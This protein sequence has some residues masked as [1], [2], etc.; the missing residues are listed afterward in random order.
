MEDQFTRDLTDLGFQLAGRD[1]RG[2]LQYARRPNRYLTQWVHDDGTY[3][4]FT[5][6]FDL[7]EFVAGLEWQIGAAEHSMHILY[8][9][10]DVRVPRETIAVVGEIERLELR[11]AR[12]DLTD[13]QL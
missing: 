13:P 9:Q 8:P 1:R 6:E 11:M 2:V 10:R 12:L 5:W 4:L 3:A 7:G